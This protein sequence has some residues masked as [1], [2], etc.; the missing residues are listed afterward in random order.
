MQK[1]HQPE[2]HRITNEPETLDE[3]YEAQRINNLPTALQPLVALHHLDQL[4]ATPSYAE[5][6]AAD[7][8]ALCNALGIASE[9]D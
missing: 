3:A 9:A 6:N 8:V 4:E 7:F 2:Q 1:Q 5:Q